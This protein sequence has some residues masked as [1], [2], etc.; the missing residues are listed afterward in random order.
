MIQHLLKLSPPIHPLP[1]HDV[2]D[3]RHVEQVIG[4]QLPTDYKQFIN[5]YGV[6]YVCTFVNVADPFINNNAHLNL[7]HFSDLLSD[8]L[9]STRGK[10]GTRA[11]PYPIYP[12][13]GGLLAWGATDNGDDLYWQTV[14]DPDAWTIVVNE[15]RSDVY[16][17]F[18]F[19]MVEFVLKVIT[20]ELVSE[21]LPVAD[22]DR[23]VAI[24]PHR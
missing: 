16:E 14:G 21:I 5:H 3:W 2:Q 8:A 11:V 9:H 18:P 24:Q 13:Q 1:D 6:S 4:T 20:G 12:E 23:S 22:L 19:G 10:F 17:E 7:K 15:S